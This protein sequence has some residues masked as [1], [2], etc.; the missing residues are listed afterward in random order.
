MGTRWTVAVTEVFQY[1]CSRSWMPP[2]HPQVPG[3]R[4]GPFS[5]ETPPGTPPPLGQ[6]PRWFPGLLTFQVVS[7][8]RRRGTPR[9]RCLV[10]RR[11][12]MECLRLRSFDRSAFR[13]GCFR[14]GGGSRV[15]PLPLNNSAA[16][17]VKHPG[18][19][20]QPLPGRPPHL[21]RP[22]LREQW[23]EAEIRSAYSG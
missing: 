21:R 4:W 13:H 18:A 14:V 22:Q 9:S 7:A 23:R 8:A 5:S 20:A 19:T 1:L 12:R 6:A 3:T 16:G 10:P 17:T 11:G 2:F 15:R